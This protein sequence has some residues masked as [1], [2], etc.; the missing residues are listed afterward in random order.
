MKTL[1]TAIL[2]IALS[3]T[4]W[5]LQIPDFETGEGCW[6]YKVREG[7]PTRSMSTDITYMGFEAVNEVCDGAVWGC[8]KPIEHKIY[9]YRFAGKVTL[10][11]EQCHSLGLYEHNNC[12]GYG[13]GKD[14][15]A[16]NW[17][18]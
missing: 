9:L 13:I 3:T 8:Y 17:N 2:A 1:I 6:H 12:T 18:N 16:C 10:Y 11:E 5:A 7:T 14:K 15:S 4:A